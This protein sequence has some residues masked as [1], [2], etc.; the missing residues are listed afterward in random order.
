M[1]WETDLIR[2]IPL[3]AEVCQWNEVKVGWNQNRFFSL[4]MILPKDKIWLKIW[5]RVSELSLSLKNTVGPNHWF[6]LDIGTDFFEFLY[7][8]LL[9]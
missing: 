1:L 6:L 9:G 2:Y 4:T 3:K 7:N 5:K 8:F